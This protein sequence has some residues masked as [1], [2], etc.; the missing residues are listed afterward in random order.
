LA[1]GFTV[2]KLENGCRKRRGREMSESSRPPEGERIRGANNLTL[3][4]GDQLLGERNDGRVR[5]RY[6]EETPGKKFLREQGSRIGTNTERA[7][8]ANPIKR[9]RTEKLDLPGKKLQGGNARNKSR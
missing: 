1:R 9:G 3:I 2:L 6:Q 5:M 4:K 7:M 8:A